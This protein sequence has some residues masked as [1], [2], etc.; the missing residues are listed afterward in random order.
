[1]KIGCCAPVRDAGLLAKAGFDFCEENIQNLLIA[2][3]PEADFARSLE[4]VRHSPLPI[5]AANCFLPGAL[6]CTGPEIDLPRLVRYAET[7]FRRAA[8]AGIRFLVFGSGAARQVPEGF[9][10]ERA[11]AQMIDYGRRIA[12]LAEQH[13]VVIALE[14][15]NQ[16]ECNFI[17]SLAE[18]AEVVA[19]V[20]HPHVRLLADFFH[21]A[22]AG[23]SAEEIVRFGDSIAHVHVAENAGRRAPGTAGEDFGPYLRA[24]K[25]I[26]YHGAL[27]FECS[28]LSL[29]EE[30]GPALKNIR[31]QLQAAGLS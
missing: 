5:R 2:E 21:M 20:H 23:E 15:L 25:E 17:N 18:G 7:A 28:W 16:G 19:A 31:A 12:P 6:K 11:L 1:M 22:R 9:P 30:A 13:G 27:S 4:A 14:P 3:A 10:R 29:S 24:L 26:D 8:L